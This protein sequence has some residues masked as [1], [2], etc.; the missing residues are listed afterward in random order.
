MMF[1]RNI[2][3]VSYTKEEYKH[4]LLWAHDYDKSLFI[5]SPSSEWSRIYYNMSMLFKT[6]SFDFCFRK[7]M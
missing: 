2:E 6:N 1:N 3:P 7:K 5:G 4:S